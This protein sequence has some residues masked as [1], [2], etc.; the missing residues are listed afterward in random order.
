MQ[1]LNEQV[2]EATFSETLKKAQILFQTSGKLSL[3]QLQTKACELKKQNNI[4]L[5]AIDYFRLMSFDEHI[6]AG[7]YL[8][9][10]VEMTNGIKKLAKDL[11][12]PIIVLVK[13]NRGSLDP[14]SQVKAFVPEADAV[15]IL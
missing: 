10:M 9:G 15:T 6:E 2:S 13:L 5:I 1:S 14:M 4:D 3:V 11:M 12:I 8:Q 7:N